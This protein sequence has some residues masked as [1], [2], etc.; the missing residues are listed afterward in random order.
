MN[1]LK[2]N[3]TDTVRETQFDNDLSR[4]EYF[5]ETGETFMI[6]WYR[7]NVQIESSKEKICLMK[8]E[9]EFFQIRQINKIQ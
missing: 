9:R 2:D 5:N 8:L 1:I 6:E 4:K 7:N 3:I